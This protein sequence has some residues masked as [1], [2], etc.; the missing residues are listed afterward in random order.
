MFDVIFKKHFEGKFSKS[1]EHLWQHVKAEIADFQTPTYERDT[2]APIDVL[3]TGSHL[4]MLLYVLDELFYVYKG[5]G[6]NN[7]DGQ[8]IVAY[9]ILTVASL[10]CMEWHSSQKKGV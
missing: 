3:R 5:V 6:V 4:C 2:G 8:R 1:N 7:M 9:K 10:K